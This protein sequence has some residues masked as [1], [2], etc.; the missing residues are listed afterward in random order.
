MNIFCLTWHKLESKRKPGIFNVVTLINNYDFIFV[1]QFLNMK[2]SNDIITHLLEIL[3]HQL[4]LN[5]SI[6]I[7]S[8]RNLSKLWEDSHETT[9]AGGYHRLCRDGWGYIFHGLLSCT[10]SGR[11]FLILTRIVLG[12]VSLKV[13]TLLVYK[14]CMCHSCWEISNWLGFQGTYCFS[15]TRHNKNWS[16]L[17]SIFFYVILG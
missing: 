5:R 8:Y 13:V 16:W 4:Q 12:F 17:R 6:S 3:V 14:L 15:E 2:V 7:S 11:D 9:F 1:N 10:K